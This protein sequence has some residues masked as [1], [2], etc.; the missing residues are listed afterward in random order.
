MVSGGSTAPIAAA[1]IKKVDQELSLRGDNARALFTISLIDERFGEAGHPDSNWQRLVELGFNPFAFNAVPILAEKIPGGDTPEK[2]AVRLDSF[3][4]RAVQKEREGRLFISCLFG[5]GADGHTAG[6]LP[7]S[8]ASLLPALDDTYGCFYPSTPF[9]R[10]TI[11]P[12]FFPHVDL[13][14]AWAAGKEKK[15][16][17]A[18]LLTEIPVH[19]QPAQLLKLPKETILFTDIQE[20][21]K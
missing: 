2:A 11:T 17:L 20:K 3:L 19:A 9:A 18:S 14:V 1:V 12:S 13:A 7:D 21:I 8:P 15:E 4:H 16:A 6:I 5:I 10:I